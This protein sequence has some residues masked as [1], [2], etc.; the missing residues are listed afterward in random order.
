MIEMNEAAWEAGVRSGFAKPLH[1][2]CPYAGGSP[3]AFAWNSGRIEG[4]AVANGYS[5]KSV[6]QLLGSE[7]GQGSRPESAA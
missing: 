2:K 3:E 1:D 6:E 5:S 7:E 4:Q